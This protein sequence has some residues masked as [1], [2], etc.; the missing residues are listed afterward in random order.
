MAELLKKPKA[1]SGGRKIENLVGEPRV[2]KP[3]VLRVDKETYNV[4]RSFVES[5]TKIQYPWNVGILR[6]DVA[7]FEKPG[8][9]EL[10]VEIIPGRPEKRA[11]LIARNVFIKVDIEPGFKVTGLAERELWVRD[12]NDAKKFDIVPAEDVLYARPI[13]LAEFLNKIM[14]Y[15]DAA[16]NA[17]ADAL[18]NN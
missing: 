17:Y 3:E 6:G 15:V 8:K 2:V 14:M 4:I 10:T 7:I 9:W 13:S 11:T 16:V 1:T 18:E 5:S 12:I